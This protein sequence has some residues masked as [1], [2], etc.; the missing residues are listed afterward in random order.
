MHYVAACGSESLDIELDGTGRARIGDREVRYEVLHQ[1]GELWQLLIDGRP[2]V[3][4]VRGDESGRRYTVARRGSPLRMTLKSELETRLEAAGGGAGGAGS[5]VRSLMPGVVIK[6]LI[7][8][9]DTV[10][11][12]EVLLVLE[13]MKMQNE[14]RAELAGTVAKVHVEPGL[15]VAADALLVEIEPEA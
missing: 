12:G 1:D 9:G 11:S 3:G 4:V 15:A 5:E 8:A 10:A 14:I 13:A 2:W 6:V 7:G